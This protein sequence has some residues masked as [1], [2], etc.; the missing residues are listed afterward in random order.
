[1]CFEWIKEARSIMFQD[2]CTQKTQILST[3]RLTQWRVERFRPAYYDCISFQNHPALIH[4]WQNE[5]QPRRR[6][7]FQQPQRLGAPKHEFL[8]SWN[9]SASRRNLRIFSELFSACPVDWERHHCSL[10]VESVHW[11][12]WDFKQGWR[13][14]I[15]WLIG[16]AWCPLANWS[17]VVCQSRLSKL[18]M[19]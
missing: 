15:S 3:E 16:N 2:L 8:T 9:S 18:R 4:N 1:M 19:A 17:K 12:T 11:L 7:Q 10:R 13:A 5:F 6:T 14:A